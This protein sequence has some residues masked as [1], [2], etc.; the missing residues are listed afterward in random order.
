MPGNVNGKGKAI[1]VGRWRISPRIVN[2]RRCP[3]RWTANL[4]TLDSFHSGL[5][6]TCWPWFV[7]DLWTFCG[8]LGKQW[9]VAAGGAKFNMPPNGLGCWLKKFWHMKGKLHSVEGTK[10]SS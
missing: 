4:S 7:T 9:P 2:K 1:E 10:W 3:E 6:G 8:S 5:D